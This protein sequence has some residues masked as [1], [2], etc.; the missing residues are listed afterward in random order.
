MRPEEAMRRWPRLTAHL[1]SVS[2]GYFTPTAAA[3]AIA[4]Y[5]ADEPYACEW[6]S[7]MASSR[8]GMYDHDLLLEVGRFTLA[9]AFEWRHHHTGYMAHYPQAIA[10]VRH[11][12]ATTREPALASWF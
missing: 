6:Y 3:N 4:H 2:L 8:G 7:H 11:A 9:K 12:L 10:L 1:I 5:K